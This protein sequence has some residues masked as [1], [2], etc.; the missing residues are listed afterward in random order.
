MT[1]LKIS[2]DILLEELFEV[3]PESKKILEKYGYRKLVEL[4]IEDVVVDKLS[5]KGFF[6]LMKVGEDE[7][8]K[9]VREIHSLY[10]KKLEES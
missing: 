1:A 6:R 9:V 4:G 2:E 7:V 10:N 5:L 3:L 8:G